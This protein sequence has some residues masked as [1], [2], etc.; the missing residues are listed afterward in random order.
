MKKRILTSVLGVLLIPSLATADSTFQTL[1]FDFTPDGSQTLNFPKFDI[2]LGTLTGVTIGFTLTKTGGT[3]EVDND[4]LSGGSITLNHSLAGSLSSPDVAL[5]N[6]SFQP[7]GTLNTVSSYTQSIGAT[8]GDATNQFDRTFAADYASYS[9]AVTSSTTSGAVSSLVWSGYEGIGTFA[10]NV[11]A[12]Q[13][14]SITGLGGV[15]LTRTVSQASGDVT[16][17]YDFTPVPEP[18]TWAMVV[19]GVGMFAFGRRLSRR[20]VQS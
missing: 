3:L 16:V 2:S 17:T 11:N 10:I 5:F 4:S 19:G 9:P 13:G 8:T 15:Q 6:T 12:T 7:I 14:A 1:T 20:S 18:S